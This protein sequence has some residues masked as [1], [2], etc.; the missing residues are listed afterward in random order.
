MDHANNCLTQIK[1]KII[2][3]DKKRIITTKSKQKT[4]RTLLERYMKQ[5]KEHKLSKNVKGVKYLGVPLD[6]CEEMMGSINVGRPG[7]DYPKGETG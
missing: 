7:E 3:E 5:I 6:R 4:R 2:M 1:P